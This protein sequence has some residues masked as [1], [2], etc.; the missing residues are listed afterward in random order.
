MCVTVPDLR[1]A[2]RFFVDVIGANVLFESGPHSAADGEGS[3]GD[4][5]WMYTQLRMHPQSTLLTACLKL[6]PS[7]VLEL[8]EVD[9]PDQRS[10][11][12]RPH[13]A[14]APHLAFRVTDMNAAVE[15]LRRQEGVVVHGE[16]V[17]MSS[18]PIAGVR[19]LHFET[20]WGLVLEID[21]WPDR[22]PF[23]DAPDG[24]WTP[25]HDSW[26]GGPG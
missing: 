3:E 4:P 15:Y 13:D 5:D 25:F 20:P 14:G 26:E 17:E 16:P 2:V 7:F 18:G 21:E 12:P 23:E 24:G 9:A 10:S 11:H 22:V 1:E 8:Y 6:G 19:W